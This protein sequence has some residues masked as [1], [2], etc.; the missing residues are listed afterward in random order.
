ME[1]FKPRHVKKKGR[2]ERVGK[3]IHDGGILEG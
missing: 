3:G 1:R 2:R